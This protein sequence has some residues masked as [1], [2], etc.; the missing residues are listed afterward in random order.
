VSG[1]VCTFQAISRGSA[2]PRRPITVA[3]VRGRPR[4]RSLTASWRPALFWN[5]PRPVAQPACDQI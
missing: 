2:R 5:R 4:R 3:R 1:P